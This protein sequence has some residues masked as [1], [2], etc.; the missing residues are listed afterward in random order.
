MPFRLILFDLDGTLADTQA[1]LAAAVN[2]TRRWAGLPPLGLPAIRGAIGDGARVLI[3]RTV[4]F[5][6]PVEEPLR[7]FI[8]YYGTHYAVE[9]RLYP[10]VPEM[11]EATRDRLRAIVTN[12]PERISRKILKALAVD[13]H[14]V[15]VI[16]GDSL[17]ARKPD[18]AGILALMARHGIPQAE[19]LMVGDSPVDIAAARA[20]GVACAVL[21]SG[22]G[23]PAALQ[24]SSPDFLLRDLRGLLKILRESGE[25]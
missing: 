16:G 1:D 3:E 18:P 11:L 23:D 12:K 5:S 19:T 22:Y 14:F 6:G 25:E 8:D 2:A 7:F 21:E 10:G 17:P 9:T 13:G 24:A 15:D 4:S 20:A